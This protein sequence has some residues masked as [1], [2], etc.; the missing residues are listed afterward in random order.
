MGKK[1]RSAKGEI[2]DFDLLKVKEQIA[3]APAPQDVKMRQDFIE[4][5]MRRRLKKVPAPAP[6]LDLSEDKKDKTVKAEPKMPGT[7]TLSEEPKLID[8]VEEEKKPRQRARPPK[9]T[10]SK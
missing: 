6:K 5:R 10:D 4:K 1:I 7:E 9:D 8:E 2:V 3:S